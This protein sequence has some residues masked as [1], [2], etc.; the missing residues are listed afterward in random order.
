MRFQTALAGIVGFVCS[1]ASA[2]AP[3]NPDLHL[4]GDLAQKLGAK[5]ELKLIP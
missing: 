2:P 4:G 5:P 3:S 1:V